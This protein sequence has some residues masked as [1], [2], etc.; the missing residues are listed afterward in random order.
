MERNT[1]VA[2][3]ANRLYW[4]TD[5]SVADIAETLGVS[6]RALYE[7]ISGDEAG[8]LCDSCGGRLVFA[9]RSARAAGAARCADCGNECSITVDDGETQDAP[10]PYAAGWPRPDALAELNGARRSLKIGIAALAGVAVG[11]VAV[12]L[13]ARRR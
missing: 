10:P 6:R 3:E 11:A 13:I 8:V 7:L 5:R 2:G 12:L 1:A 9:N 4:R